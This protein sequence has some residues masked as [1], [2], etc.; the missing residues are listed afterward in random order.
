MPED[1]AIATIAAIAWAVILGGVGGVMTDIGPWYR[2]L[3]NPAW[4]NYMTVRLN[5][6]FV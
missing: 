6:P 1:A 5:R 4:L 2:N 3:K